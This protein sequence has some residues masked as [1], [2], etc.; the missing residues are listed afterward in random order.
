VFNIFTLLPK[1]IITNSSPHCVQ[2]REIGD[3]FTD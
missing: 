3:H 2:G 1:S